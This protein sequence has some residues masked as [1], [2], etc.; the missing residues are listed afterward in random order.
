MHGSAVVCTGPMPAVG[1]PVWDGVGTLQGSSSSLVALCQVVSLPRSHTPQELLCCIAG[2]P[3][4]ACTDLLV[5]ELMLD[6]MHRLC[7]GC[8]V[9]LYVMC[10]VPCV[11]LMQMNSVHIAHMCNPEK[12]RSHMHVTPQSSRYGQ[13]SGW[14]I[15][16]TPSNEP[17]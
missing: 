7:E 13:A 6:H 12:S 1:L 16:C 5:E 11:L 3:H 17:S 8:L 14:Q 2:L 15:I 4:H 10:V 9:R